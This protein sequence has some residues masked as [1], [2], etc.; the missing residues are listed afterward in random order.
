MG[1]AIGI[2]LGTTNSVAAFKEVQAEIVTSEDNTPPDRKLTRSV[3]TYEQDKFLVGEKAYNQLRHDPE[4][5]IMS[6]K[7]LMGRGFGDLAV[8]KQKEEFSYK[9]TQPT[10]G[11]DNSIAVWLGGKE[12]QPEDISAEILKKVVRN[13]QDYRKASGKSNEVINQAVI[14]I[15]AYFNDKQRSSTRTAALKAGLTLQELLPE[16]TAAA[17]S[18]G[19]SP[20]SEDVKTILVYDFGGGTF[21]ACLI[22]AAGTSFIENGKA[23]DLWL[24]GDDIDSKIIQFVKEQVAKQEQVSNIDELIAKMPH[25]QKVRFMADLKMGVERAKVELSNA[26]VAKIIPVTPLLDELGIAIPVAVEI[27]REQFEV[28]IMPLVERSVEIC[29]QALQYSEYLPDMVDVVLLVGG[30]SQIPLVHRKVRQAFGADKVVVHPRPMYAVAEGAALV[31]AGLTDK[32][33]TVSRDYFIKLESEHRYKVISQG[34][35]LPVTTAHTFKTI[36]DGQRLI[37]FKFFSPDQVSSNLDKINRDETLGDMWLGLD[38]YYP[39]GTEVMVNL[40][41]DEKNNDLEITATLKNDPSVRV[42]CTF[43]RGRSDER[44]NKEL[45]K[46]IEDLNTLDLTDFGVKEALK[47]AVPVVQAT[48]QIIDV[49]TREE[50]TDIRD[51]AQANL[52][53]LQVSMSKERSEAEYLANECERV[54]RLCGSLIPQPQQERLQRLKSQLD[55]AIENNNESAMQS[56]SEDAEQEIRNLPDEVGIIRACFMAIGNAKTVAPTQASA[57]AEKVSRMV[58]ALERQDGREADRLWSELQPDVSHWLN[59]EQT[60]SKNIVTGLTR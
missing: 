41:L 1:K 60:S 18:Y 47:L 28:I 55:A 42:S 24:G 43:S 58:S 37:H 46:T 45:E 34:D 26:T 16:P 22:T 7:R 21:D 11:T 49:R 35:I 30:S 27:T 4:N 2:D 5:V 52:K 13:A 36:A 32:V 56:L 12:Y 59:G 10:Q 14:T 20:D 40:E 53:K 15:P 44:I 39:Q 33:T 25:Y 8:Q 23:G 29:H 31:A 50:R 6:I 54:V 57:M 51:R 48:N 38:Q 17:I 9:I 3:V 19:Y